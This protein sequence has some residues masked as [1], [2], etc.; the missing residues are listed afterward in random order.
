VQYLSNS[1]GSVGIGFAIPSNLAKNVIDQITLIL[2]KLRE[3]I[4]ELEYKKLQKKL[5][6]V[7]D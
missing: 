6:I 7:L 3:D 5:Q 1:G 2:E 4:L